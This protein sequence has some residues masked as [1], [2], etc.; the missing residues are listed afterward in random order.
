VPVN[1]A[2]RALVANGDSVLIGGFIITGSE[3][4]RVIARAIGP[5][6]SQFGI[7]DALID[8]TLELVPES[9]ASTF[10]D[11]WQDSDAAA[12]QATGIPPT[13][14]RESAIVQTLPP[15]RYTAI[16]RSRT[17]TPGVGLIELYDLNTDANAHFGNLS[18]RGLI[19]EGNDHVMIGGVIVGEGD[20]VNGAGS[21]RVAVRGMGPSLSQSGVA[22]ALQDPELLL[23]DPNGNVIAAND[24]WRD[25][26]A[27]E[28]TAVG[29]APGDDR[30]AA[31][32]A[33]LRRGGYTAVVRGKSM[34]TGV[35]LVE[36][37]YI[38]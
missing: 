26:Q 24:N 17:N 30:E 21:A 36:V 33:T 34:T 22:G 18:S 8:P 15:G 32:V 35:A 31:L 25:G 13:D 14:A 11:N 28:L 23:F 20:G 3:S 16:V 2:T 10:N 4:K 27:T 29:L 7:T 38:Q 12:I 1:I 37:Y 6:L 19:I 9:G 5:S